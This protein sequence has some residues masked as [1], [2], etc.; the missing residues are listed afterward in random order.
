[1]VTVIESGPG[2]LLH[3][4]LTNPVLVLELDM[5][6]TAGMAAAVLVVG[7]LLVSRSS[8]LRRYCI[9]AA[10]MGGLIFA[11][12]HLALHS[13]GVL[14]FVFDTTLQ[15]MFMIVFFCSIGFMASFRRLR[16]GGKLVVILLASTALLVFMQDVIGTGLSVIMGI[17]GGLGLAMGSMSLIGGHGTAAAF[18]P[19]LEDAYGVQGATAVAIASA[20]FGLVIGGIIGGPLAKRRVER[21][22]LSP[23]DEDV[24]ESLEYGRHEAFGA[25]I[26]QNRFLNALVLLAIAIGTGTLVTGGLDALGVTLPIYIGSM[27]IAVFFRNGM[28]KLG[29][30]IP[31]KEIETLGWISLAMFLGMALMNMKL[32]QIADLSAPML[33]ILIAQVAFVALFAYYLIFRITGKDYD[34]AAM[35][36]ATCGF[37]LGTTSNAMV[38]MDALFERYGVAPKAYFVVPLVGSVFIDLINIAIITGFLSIL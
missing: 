25:Q 32:W 27:L 21:Y 4:A 28:D 2:F 12:I 35:V 19:L 31:S 8:L 3:N 22:S 1:M 23:S 7:T 30:N 37:G 6:Q 18:G 9:P 13:A 26:D 10:V 20:T 17:D 33:V 14:E 34:S 11:M 15:T 38:N 24:K 29:W 5:Y 16:S 36:T